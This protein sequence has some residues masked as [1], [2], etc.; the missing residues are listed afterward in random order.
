MIAAGLAPFFFGSAV[1]AEQYD[2]A[3]P[4]N[5]IMPRTGSPAPAGA[6]D[7]EY[8][9][10]LTQ[11]VLGYIQDSWGDGKLPIWRK[12]AAQVDLE[13]R[14]A[15][16]AW[17]AIQGAREHAGIHH[18][19]PAWVLAQMMSES[20]YYEF[21]ISYAFAVGP[22]QFI[23]PTARS[24]D[25]LCAG[26]LPEHGRPPYAL[27]GQADAIDEYARVRDEL[28]AFRRDNHSLRVTTERMEEVL[29]AVVAGEPVPRAQD[30]LD[31][32]RGAET[33]NQLLDEARASFREYLRANFE[34]RDIFDAEDLAFLRGFDERVT[35]RKP[36]PAMVH[37][38][39][40]GLQSRN[41]NIIA[42]AAGFHAG[43]GNTRDTGHYEAYG[44]MPGFE[45]TVAYMSRVFI[46]HHEIAKRL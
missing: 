9:W 31:Y 45:S 41:G 24:Y 26:D 27:P 16:I 21:A 35:Y 29:E 34:G 33:M 6:T 32:I 20:F 12:P 28:R 36:V 42:A 7:K 4:V 13:K 25:M 14:V 38:L 18:V 44:R 22:C 17:W 11:A 2:P 8:A 19:D 43:L 3:D 37:M 40:S 15:N 39:A 30:Q 46:N 10:R 1:R 23:A 5:I